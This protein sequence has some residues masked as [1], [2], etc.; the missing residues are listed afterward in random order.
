MSPQE[1]RRRVIAPVVAAL[2]ACAIHVAVARSLRLTPFGDVGRGSGDYGPQYIPFHLY[3]HDVIHGRAQGSVFFSWQYLSGSGFLPE[4]ATY[5]SGP[6]T[7]LVALFPRE[8]MDTAILCVSLLRIAMAV[9]L[10]VVLLQALRPRAPILPGMLLA[11]GYGCSSWTM[12]LGLIVPMW[13]DGLWMFPAFCLAAVWSARRRALV[14]PVLVIAIGWWSQFYV[15]LMAS[16]GAG[17]FF[18][19]WLVA[20]RRPVLPSMLRFAGRGVLA[21]GL[22]GSLIIP[23]F[24]AIRAGMP[25]PAPESSPSVTAVALGQFGHVQGVTRDPMVFCGS[26][27]LVLALAVSLNSQLPARARLAW[28]ALLGFALVSP[29]VPFVIRVFNGGDHPNG[30][31]YRWSFVL[32]GLIVIVAW[33]SV[34][35]GERP[36]L[37]PRQLAVAFTLYAVMVG[38]AWAGVSPDRAPSARWFVLPAVLIVGLVLVTS[39]P[40]WWRLGQLILTLF[41]VLELALSAVLVVPLSRVGYGV[42]EP[43]ATSSPGYQEAQS[44]QQRSSWPRGRPS[45]D[46]QSGPAWIK[47]NVGLRWGMTTLDGYSS[48][49]PM[50]VMR[51]LGHWGLAKGRFANTPPGNA[52]IAEAVFA[53]SSHWD[54]NG[55]APTRSAL[56]MVRTIPQDAAGFRAQGR[57][58]LF[59]RPV[60]SEART[61]VWWRD[62]HQPPVLREPGLWEP[63][64]GVL[65]EYQETCRAGQVTS[66]LPNLRG[67]AVW[68]TNK[69]RQQKFA[70]HGQAITDLG[71]SVTLSYFGLP[72]R[73]VPELRSFCFDR[74]EL[75]AEIAETEVPRITV[76]GSRITARFAKPQAGVVVIATVHQRGWQCTADGKKA[77]RVGRYGLLGVRV[78][79]ATEVS[80]SYRQPGLRLGAA[81]S[82]LALLVLALLPAMGWLHRSGRLPAAMLRPP[83]VDRL[84]RHPT[85][86]QVIRFGLVG[87]ANTAVYYLFYRLL[88]G[89]GLIYLA[90]HLVAWAV[91]VVFSFW[92]NCCFTYHVRPTWKRFAA[93]PATTLVNVAFS[94]VGSWVCV[95]FFGADKRYVTLLMGI[96]AIPFTFAIT[97]F[98][99]TGRVTADPDHASE[100]AGD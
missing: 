16:L 11:V 45:S 70:A 57:A 42:S 12:Q 51:T 82:S 97:K 1:L 83:W 28:S 71:S 58:A 26:L 41:V 56:P 37:A 89:S 76:Q 90:A 92:A 6:F 53:V 93:F 40:R 68:V 5:L 85:T 80:C 59:A 2:A 3:L 20:R 9:G 25:T 94:T 8:Q 38:L 14:G 64:Q 60:V 43:F 7:P 24:M 39:L 52:D 75:D 79:G 81:V 44:V 34:P 98:V 18:L 88:L 87:V 23:T 46:I 84:V 63:R 77:E 10:M 22:C 74:A 73:P 72:G 35:L 91:S 47:Y 78:H 49:A 48:L 54:G 100:R 50:D 27:A 31:P 62:N 15:A 19:A 36:W 4:Y 99:L 21:V 69:N 13:L 67:K 66:I 30:N 32:A 55:S 29:L 95:E 33:H 61:R 96:L 86:G 17:L 65:I